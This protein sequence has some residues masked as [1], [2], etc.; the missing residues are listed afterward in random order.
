MKAILRAN[1][2]KKSDIALMFFMEGAFTA[3]VQTGLAIIVSV[4]A[5][6]MV[7][8]TLAEYLNIPILNK[9]YSP[10]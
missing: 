5:I 8:A 2:A 6:P 3:L 9:K 4:V 10:L 1:G 7:N